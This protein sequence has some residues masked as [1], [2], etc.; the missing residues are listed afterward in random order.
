MNYTH[1]YTYIIILLSLLS[2]FLCFCTS[3]KYKKK[4]KKIA[5]NATVEFFLLFFLFDNHRMKLTF[6]ALLPVLYSSLQ[7]FVLLVLQPLIHL[8]VHPFHRSIHPPLLLNHSSLHSVHFYTN[9]ENIWLKRWP[10][11]RSSASAWFYFWRSTHLLHRAAVKQQ[12]FLGEQ[13]MSPQISN[14]QTHSHS[15]Y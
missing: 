14:I 6:S 9:I 11:S 12:S 13:T 10:W 2:C 15:L 5:L 3:S 7:A 1:I 4:K 8:V